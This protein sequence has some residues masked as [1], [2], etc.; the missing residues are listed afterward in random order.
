MDFLEKD[1][2]EDPIFHHRFRKYMAGPKRIP[3]KNNRDMETQYRINFCVNWLFGTAL[4]WPV[5]VVVGRRMKHTAGGV[6][7]FPIQRFVDDF[8]NLEPG[9]HARK[10]F[11]FWST[12]TCVGLGYVFAKTVCDWRP[13]TNQWSN[14]PDLKPHAAMVPD[15]FTGKDSVTY[16]TMMQ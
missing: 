5:A 9:R 15:E 2:R 4:A 13:A 10:T 11:F 1:F 6:P 16:K 14:R 7:A 8:P 3:W 12:L